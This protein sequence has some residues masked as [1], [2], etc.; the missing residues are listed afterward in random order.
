M[1]ATFTC[2]S[3]RVAFKDAEVQRQHYKTDWHRYNLKRKIAEL[4]PVTAED[5]QRRVL[6]QREKVEADAQEVSFYCEPCRKAFSSQNAYDNH[7]LSKKHKEIFASL[8][9]EEGNEPVPAVPIKTVSKKP[10]EP[11]HVDKVDNDDSDMEEVDSD[12][13][14]DEGEAIPVT[15]CLFCTHHSASVSKNLKH[16]AQSHTFFVPDMEYVIDVTGLLSYLGG[17]IGQGFM[18]LWCSEHG[19]AFWS[20]DATQRHMRDKGHCKMKH[21]GENLAE[22]ADFYD[23]SSSYPDDADAD[24][25]VDIPTID[26]S[27]FQLTLP[28]GAVIGHRS[29]MRYFRLV[30][31]MTQHQHINI[32]II[33][34][35]AY[36]FYVCICTFIQYF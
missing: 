24:M 32:I 21:E 36:T 23:F 1:M 34:V 5:F 28:S 17:K 2:I 16:M 29:L 11:A 26:D 4:P 33:Y 3:C 7:L 9:L 18:C 30:L 27:D 31:F 19:K 20:A 13:W 8:I 22:F 15:D 6:L 14:N 12:G 35:Q 10:V 25:E